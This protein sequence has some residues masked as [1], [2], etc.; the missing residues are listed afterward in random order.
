[1]CSARRGVILVLDRWG[2]P[3]KVAKALLADPLGRFGVEW[4]PPYARS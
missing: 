3:K 2:V 4:L 1:M